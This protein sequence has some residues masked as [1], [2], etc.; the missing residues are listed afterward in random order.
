MSYIK[1]RKLIAGDFST[2]SQKRTPKSLT[3]SQAVEW[4]D[5]TNL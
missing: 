5:S 2:L 1:G 4:C 3:E